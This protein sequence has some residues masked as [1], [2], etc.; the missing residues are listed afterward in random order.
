VFSLAPMVLIALALIG[1]FGRNDPAGA[2]S[3]I[4]QQMSYF[5]DKSAIHVVQDIAQHVAAPRASALGGVIGVAVALFGVTGVFTQLQYSLNVIWG[6]K[7]KPGG[8]IWGFLRSRLLSFALLAAIAFLLLVSLVIEALIK[9]LSL[10]FETFLPG[11]LSVIVPIYLIID[12]IV[13]IAVFAIIFKIF[14]NVTTRWRDIWI[15][16]VLTAILFLIG[17]YALGIYLGSSTAASAYGAASSLITLLLWVYYSSQILLFG[18]EF[19]QV[20]ANRSGADIE[21]D[22][23]SVRIERKEIERPAG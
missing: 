1:F 16:A 20:Y 8:G 15:G 9:G 10:Y 22:K 3:L 4:I 12:L 19:T 2:W 18:A 23:Y 6:V 7:A 11:S 17:K 13:V 21:P 14:P 5:L